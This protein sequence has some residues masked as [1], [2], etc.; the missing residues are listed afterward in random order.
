MS[1][2][3]RRAE[4]KREFE[5]SL[6]REAEESDRWDNLSIASK[7]DE[8]QDIGDVKRVLTAIAEAAGLDIYA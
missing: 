1:N 4:R 6:A 7:I 3:R 5:E 8:I 2:W